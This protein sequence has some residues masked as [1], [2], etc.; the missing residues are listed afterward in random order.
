MKLK[1]NT[2]EAFTRD[3]KVGGDKVELDLP[4]GPYTK[5]EGAGSLVVAGQTL[6]GDFALKIPRVA[7]NL[8]S[9]GLI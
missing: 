9:V 2:G 3:V 8:L 1:I 7:S 5:F 6:S 4:A